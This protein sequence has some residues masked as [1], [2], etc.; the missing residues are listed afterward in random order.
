MCGAS[1]LKP[2]RSN[3][4]HVDYVTD[5]IAP[6]VDTGSSRLYAVLRPSLTF[7]CFSARCG[8]REIAGESLHGSHSPQIT[9]SYCRLALRKSMDFALI[10]FEERALCVSSDH[11]HVFAERKKWAQRRFQQPRF[12]RRRS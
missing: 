12:R 8:W 1:T 4:S 7:T 3:G 11:K 6:Y 9:L 2:S 5:S 10:A